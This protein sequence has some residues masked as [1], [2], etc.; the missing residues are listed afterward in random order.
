MS[1]LSGHQQSFRGQPVFSPVCELTQ[2]HCH[3]YVA[4]LPITTQIR[5]RLFLEVT[6]FS[7]AEPVLGKQI[8]L[9]TNNN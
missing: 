4:Y 9:F 7:D 5:H 3:S 8:T 1:H 2:L 6:I